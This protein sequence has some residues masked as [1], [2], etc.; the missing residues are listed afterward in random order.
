MFSLPTDQPLLIDFF[1]V[2]FFFQD[3]YNKIVGRP[4]DPTKFPR[5]RI[6]PNKNYF[7]DRLTIMTKD[8]Q[9]RDVYVMTKLFSIPLNLL[10]L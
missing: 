5:S 3:V 10:S 7:K 1:K 4:T 9:L 2:I 6:T 8:I